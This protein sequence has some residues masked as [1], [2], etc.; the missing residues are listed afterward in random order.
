MITESTTLQ[1][2]MASSIP[3]LNAPPKSIVQWKVR[4]PLRAVTRNFSA[5]IQLLQ[6]SGEKSQGE[7]PN[8]QLCTEKWDGHYVLF[9]YLLILY[10]GHWR[11]YTQDRF[12]HNS[13]VFQ[14][15]SIV[16]NFSAMKPDCFR[17]C[18]T[19]PMGSC[20]SHSIALCFQQKSWNTKK[21]KDCKSNVYCTHCIYCSWQ[22]GMS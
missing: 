22:K 8:Y 1:E 15:N 21:N 5:W 2:R 10:I 18:G 11:V 9:Y 14:M 7:H 13:K 16:R 20:T 12:T 3:M 6:K 4:W 19:K 17:K